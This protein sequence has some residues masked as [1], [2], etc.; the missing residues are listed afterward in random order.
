CPV[1]R[2][3][4]SGLKRNLDKFAEL[5]VNVIAISSDNKERAIDTHAAWKL[6]ELRLA[7]GLS[8]EE[9]RNWGLFISKG[10]GET[11][12][13]IEEPD[14]FSE[15]GIFLIRPDQSLYFSTIQTMPFARPQWADVLNAIKV[16]LKKDYP[17]RGEVE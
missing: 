16:V 6:A 14:Y 5:G 15:P 13:G 1:C 4:L 11:S 8:L 3:Q 7:Y 9:A 2:S 17:A 12:I 10:I